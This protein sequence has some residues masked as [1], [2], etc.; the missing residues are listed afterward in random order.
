MANGLLKPKVHVLVGAREEARALGCQDRGL[1]LMKKL[2]LWDVKAERD[3]ET[4]TEKEQVRARTSEL[5][6]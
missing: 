5:S 2:S 1:V 6:M 3:R 4:Q